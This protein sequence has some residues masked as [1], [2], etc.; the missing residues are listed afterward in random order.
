MLGVGLWY[1]RGWGLGMCQPCQDVEGGAWY[2]KLGESYLFN[3]NPNHKN[4]G[5]QRFICQHPRPRTYFVPAKFSL[6]TFQL[7]KLQNME[8]FML[9]REGDEY[10]HSIL[11]RFYL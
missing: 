5:E 9:Q 3:P 8:K 4:I 2:K 10:I 1:G 6:F 7:V 11:L